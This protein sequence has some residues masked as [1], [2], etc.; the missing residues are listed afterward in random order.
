[1]STSYNIMRTRNIKLNIFLN[2][3]ERKK[4]KKP[5]KAKLSQSNLIRNLIEKYNDKNIYNLDI[6]NIK[7]SILSV[8]K[9]LTNFKSKFKD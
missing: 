9:D 8:I 4:L 3:D 7:S 5:N 2:E 1:M 6:E